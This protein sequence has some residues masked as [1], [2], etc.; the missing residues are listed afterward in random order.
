[1]CISEQ[2]RLAHLGLFLFIDVWR[3]LEKV[4]LSTLGITLSERKE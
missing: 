2:T 4:D 3:S 1:M